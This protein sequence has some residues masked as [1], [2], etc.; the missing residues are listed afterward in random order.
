MA[1]LRVT[2]EL[3]CA[4]LFPHSVVRISGA[5]FDGRDLIF[6]VEGPDVPDCESV[7]CTFT[8]QET[9]VEFSEAL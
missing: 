6:D 9:R 7:I 4:T 8:R 5:D 3:L 1:K 2:P